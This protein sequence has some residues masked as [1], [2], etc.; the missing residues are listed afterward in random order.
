MSDDVPSRRSGSNAAR[1]FYS[2]VERQLEV[3]EAD[4]KEILQRL[5]R[6]EGGA[7]QPPDTLGQILQRIAILEEKAKETKSDQTA[8]NTWV[9]E[10]V[11]YLLVAGGGGAAAAL[12]KHAA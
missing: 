8:T 4:G 3:L 9:W 7:P 10:I 1:N 2:R 11:K 12:I 6:L 5:S